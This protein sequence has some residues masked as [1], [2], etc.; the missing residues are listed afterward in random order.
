[1]GVV[2]HTVEQE[3]QEPKTGNL[4]KYIAAV[5]GFGLLL[6]LLKIFNVQGLFIQTLDW[7]N[8]L[9]NLGIAIFFFF[10]IIAT[11]LFLPGSVL[12]LGA[13]VIFGVVKGSI[14]VLNAAT[15]GAGLAFLVGRYFARDSIER[16]IETNSKFK[17]VDE[18]VANEGWKIVFLTRL[19]PI[20]PF[21]LLNY[22]FGVTKVSFKDYITASWLGMI[23][24]SIMYVYI[25]S[26]A[27]DLATLGT[28]GVSDGGMA[29]TVIRMI[30]FIATVVVTIY[31]T[32]IAR[33]A[34]NERIESSQES[35]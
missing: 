27:G 31:V 12:T 23:P 3:V 8:G 6:Y 17:A 16:R 14:I 4:I 22:A 32:K 1:M 21:N 10:Y 34:L 2:E 5:L 20:F 28:G 18:A 35:S 30:G 9:G 33:K 24:G 15:L 26:L 11:V 13:G 19:S 25:G 29:S 7:I